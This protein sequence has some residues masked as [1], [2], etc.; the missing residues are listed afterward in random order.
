MLLLK[1][2]FMWIESAVCVPLE[3]F[4]RLILLSLWY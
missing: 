1:N 2:S 3:A 4:F